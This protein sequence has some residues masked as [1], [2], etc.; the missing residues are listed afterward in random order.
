MWL[1]PEVPSRGTNW[2]WGMQAPD[3]GMASN[4]PRTISLAQCPA[5]RCTTDVPH[6]VIRALW[7][8]DTIPPSCVVA[9]TFTALAMTEWEPSASAGRG[10]DRAQGSAHPHPPGVVAHTTPLTPCC[11]HADNRPKSRYAVGSRSVL[12]RQ[13]VMHSTMGIVSPSHSFLKLW[14]FDRLHSSSSR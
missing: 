14:A 13:C 12:F 1:F 9:S 6:L 2:A 7:P 8:C 10:V 3:R 11:A 4:A 5:L